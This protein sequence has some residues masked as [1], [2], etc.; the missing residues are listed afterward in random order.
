MTSG[1]QGPYSASQL[2]LILL[3]LLELFNSNWQGAAKCATATG[4]LL[5]KNPCPAQPVVLPA[6]RHV[7]AYL[8]LETPVL[9][10]FTPYFAQI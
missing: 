3:S 5:R 10:G 8:C 2:E 1:F 4:Q 6:S 9:L 7:C